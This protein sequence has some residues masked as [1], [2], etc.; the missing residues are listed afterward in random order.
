MQKI[1]TCWRVTPC[2]HLWCGYL[3]FSGSVLRADDLDNSNKFHEDRSARAERVVSEMEKE[4]KSCGGRDSN[5]RI[6]AE[7]DLKSCA[8]VQ[9]GYPRFAYVN[10][11]S[12][13]YMIFFY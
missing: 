6:P 8:F 11:I 9:L 3:W 2:I 1:R 4:V 5:P 7:Q 10:L 12:C 13:I